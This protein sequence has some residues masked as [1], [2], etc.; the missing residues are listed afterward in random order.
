M[1]NQRKP[2]AASIHFQR[3]SNPVLCEVHNRRAAC[4]EYLLPS[5][6]RLANIAVRDGNIMAVYQQKMAMASGKAR[7]TEGYSPL[8]EGI[9]HFDPSLPEAELRRRAEKVIEAVEGSGVK[10]VNA[11]IH[12]DEGSVDRHG[13]VHRHVHMHIVTDRT[14]ARGRVATRG[15]RADQ[16]ESMRRLQDAVAEATG[17]CRGERKGA[18]KRAHLSRA[19]LQQQGREREDHAEQIEALERQRDEARQDA[20]GARRRADEATAEH[21]GAR[22]RAEHARDV[23]LRELAQARDALTREKSAYQAERARWIAQNK[24]LASAGQTKIHTQGDFSALKREHETQT[25]SLRARIAVLERALESERGRRK[26]RNRISGRAREG[27]DP[28]RVDIPWLIREW[29]AEAH[30]A[31]Y[32]AQDGTAVLVADRE[33]I[34]LVRNQD[35]DIACA[36]RLAEKKFGGTVSIGGGAEFRARAARAATR[37]GIEVSDADLATVVEDEHRRITAETEPEDEP[38]FGR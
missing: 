3:L 7:A 29:D 21:L 10:V 30:A 33:R 27:V 14:D 19:Q 23:A 36:L 20:A 9:T 12:R 11:V 17:L 34:E 2:R 26:Y 22:R 4:P 1:A 18:S 32:R 24:R 35:D 28:Q 6:H 25:A 38:D 13:V 37:M 5:A 15:T 8:E 31:V 16:R